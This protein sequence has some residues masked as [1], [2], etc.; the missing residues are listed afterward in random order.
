MFD[1]ALP[2]VQLCKGHHEEQVCEFILHLGQC[3]RRR[4]H[5][6]IFLI[7]RS[8]GLFVQW[9]GTTSA[10]MVKG[11]MRNNSLKLFRI[12]TSG[13][14][15]NVIKRHFLSRALAASLFGGAE[16]FVIWKRVSRGTILCNNFEFG[17]VVLEMSFKDISN[18]ELWLHFC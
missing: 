1:R 5:L 4:C 8:G 11:I 17:P 13:S 2:F 14:V 7:W 3:F 18:L 15:G 10:I 16:P 6:N 9:S 12:S